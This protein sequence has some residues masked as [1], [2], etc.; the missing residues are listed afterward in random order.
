MSVEFRA[1]GSRGEI[2]LYDQV[3]QSFWG[4]GVTAKSFQKELSS[5]GKVSTINL[6][7]NSPGG[8]V[9]DGF[10]IYNQL[11]QHPARIEVS[12]DGIAASIASV[13]A[14]AGDQIGIAK[15]GMMMIHNPHGMAMGGAD[16]MER[17]AALLKQVKGN[18][19]QTYVDRAG[20]KSED[21]SAWMDEE[22]WMTADTALQYGFVDS[23]L[24]E[25]PV[26]A[27]IH[28]L[29]VFKNVPQALRQAMLARKGATPA[30]D[31]RA[32]QLQENGRRLSE[33]VGI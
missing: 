31:L 8:D 16:E 9:F 26:T 4:D 5:L 30:R 3:G 23:V 20:V 17:V 2:W 1:R 33:V 14:M 12:I 18:L 32:V 6:H 25:Q 22:T 7:I 11:K 27:C 29:S 19:V 28:D 21:V 10:A 15:N 13:I 24:A